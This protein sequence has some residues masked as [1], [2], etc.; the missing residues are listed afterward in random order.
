MEA[1]RE[2]S[3]VDDL[4]AEMQRKMNDQAPWVNEEYLLPYKVGVDLGTSNIVII[5]LDQNNRPVAG[6]LEPAHVV[7][8]GIVVEYVQAVTLL[9]SMKARLEQR[10]GTTLTH[11]ATAIPP[12]IGSGNVKVITNVVEAAGFEVTHVIDE[13]EAAAMVL[14]VVNGAVVDIGGGTTGISVIRE[15]QVI[16]SADEATGGVHM[17][18]VIA[19]SYGLDFAEAEKLKHQSGNNRMLL[20]VV[21]AV[22]EKMADIALKN[23]PKGTGK[24]YL[25]G[26]SSCLEGIEQIFAKYTALETVKPVNPLLVTPVGIAMSAGGAAKQ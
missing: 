4:M 14:G 26:G 19:G 16:L 22:V 13:P 25:A 17:T 23:I 9:R 18:L 24:I 2:L 6:E 7:R 20:P 11:A 8:D 5:V 3:L 21:Q 1:E 10:L 15:G 12:G